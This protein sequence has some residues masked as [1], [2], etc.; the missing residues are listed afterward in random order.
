MPKVCQNTINF[1]WLNKMF[2]FTCY[3]DVE[4]LC[5]ERMWLSRVASYAVTLTTIV[6][7]VSSVTLYRQVL[8]LKSNA[9]SVAAARV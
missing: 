4:G 5:S 2:A 3:D 8:A 6:F 9:D 1:F 7:L